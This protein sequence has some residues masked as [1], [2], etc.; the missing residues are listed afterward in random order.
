[1]GDLV[2]RERVKRYERSGG[3]VV[4]LSRGNLGGSLGKQAVVFS[5]KKQSCEGLGLA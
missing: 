4:N 2:V 3:K 1:M 5:K